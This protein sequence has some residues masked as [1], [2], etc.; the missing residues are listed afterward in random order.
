MKYLRRCLKYCLSSSDKLDKH[1]LGNEAHMLLASNHSVYQ[2]QDL[3]MDTIVTTV[4]VLE[5]EVSLPTQIKS[6]L[7][8]HR[9]NTRITAIFHSSAMVTTLSCA[10]WNRSLELSS[11]VTQE[12]LKGLATGGMIFVSAFML[13]DGLGLKSFPTPVLYDDHQPG[14]TFSFLLVLLKH[15]FNKIHFSMFFNI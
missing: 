3:T 2:Q 15:F 1:P 14:S 8:N 10:F 7:N 5:R 6:V 11:F 13:L 12:R 4:R 9:R